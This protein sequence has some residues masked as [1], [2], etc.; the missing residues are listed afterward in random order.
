MQKIE[1]FQQT[2]DAWL[3]KDIKKLLIVLSE[4]ILWTEYFGAQ[5]QGKAEIEKW[6]CQWNKPVENKVKSWTV[7]KYYVD[8]ETTLIT[9]TFRCFYEGKEGILDG[10]S[11]VK[12]SGNKI[13]EIQEFEQK[14]EKFR[15]FLK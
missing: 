15:P 4:D 10:I 7:D 14:Y 9:W 12:F 11:L 13:C 2:I 5:Y 6:F 1:L 3:N 8:N